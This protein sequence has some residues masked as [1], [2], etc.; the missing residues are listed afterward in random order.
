MDNGAY[1]QLAN[2]S[3]VPAEPCP[4]YTDGRPWYVVIWHIVL[5][6]CGFDEDELMEPWWKTD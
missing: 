1:R 6:F 3:W 4:F 2:G 5:V